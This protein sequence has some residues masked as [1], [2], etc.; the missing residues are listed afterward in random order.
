MEMNRL[1]MPTNMSIEITQI[2]RS[3]RKTIALVVQKDGTLIVRAPLKAPEKI[4]RE[5]AEKNTQ[6]I[7]KKQAQMRTAVS[8]PPKQ[9][10]SGE[11]FLFLGREIPLET[12]K[13]QK[14]TLILENHFKLAEF[15]LGNAE[16]VFEQWYRVQARQILSERV[17]F[18]AGQH[19]LQ[20]Q[21]IRI[22]SARTRWGSCN[23][24]GGLS[25]SW[26]LTLMP[27]DVVDYVVVH[28][29]AHTLVHNHSPRFWKL[30]ESILPS[31][32]VHRKWLRTNG[33]KVML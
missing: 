30:V 24:K 33:Q 31:Y 14:P 6:W 9:Y 16:W 11:T 27:M 23:S 13:G 22:S 15:A 10:I 19:N 28:E 1:E 29:L 17:R 26:R 21:G 32:K 8:L 20:F 4:I 25:F 7:L 3:K 18:F 2:I 12:V 5:F